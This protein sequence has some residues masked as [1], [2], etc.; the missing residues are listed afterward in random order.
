[1]G[2]IHLQNS[3]VLFTVSVV[4]L[5]GGGNIV[6]E[7]ANGMLPCLQSLSEELRHLNYCQIMLCWG[8][9]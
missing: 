8:Q 5:L 2:G 7:V 6:L 1:M 9:V 3:L 4:G